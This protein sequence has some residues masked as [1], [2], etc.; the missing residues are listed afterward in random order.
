MADGDLSA[1]H[2]IAH[3]GVALEPRREVERSGGTRIF[4]RKR[5]AGIGA[6]SPFV[7]V[8]AAASRS[9]ARRR[10]GYGWILTHDGWRS[11]FVLEEQSIFDAGLHRRERHG[12]SA[13]GV[14]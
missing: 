8:S 1:E 11:E 12:A 4:C 3:G 14:P 6:D 2:R 9:H 5:G 13:V 7:W 10:Y